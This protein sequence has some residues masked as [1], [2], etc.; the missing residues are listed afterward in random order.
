MITCY[1]VDVFIGPGLAGNAAGVCLLP[2]FPAA[3]TMQE[4]AA[5]N[6][7][8]QTAFVVQTDSSEF[9]LRWYT[10]IL[11]DD[12]CGHA[13]L[14]SAFVLK[15]V[16]QQAWPVRFHT[17]SGILEVSCDNGSLELGLPI[18]RPR[19][20]APPDQLLSALRLRTAEVHRTRDFLVVVES[21]DI[22]R[23]AK[24]ALDVLRELEPSLGGVILTAAGEDDIDYVVRFFAPAVGIDEDP[25]S[26]SAAC[27]HAPYW[28]QRLAKNTLQVRQLSA[29]GGAMR[30]RLDD[31]LVHVAGEAVIAKIGRVA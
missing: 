16:G 5:K 9:Q 12:L 18:W 26:G 13:T 14:A 7:Y 11:E 30:C 29:R 15:C 17:R 1:T 21:A 8:S 25:V 19:R 10:P 2:S 20:I 6:G 31:Q 24:P 4:I 27:T 23:S 3:Q 28:A 22:V